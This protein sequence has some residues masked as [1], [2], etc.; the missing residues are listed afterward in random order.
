MRVLD[1][2]ATKVDVSAEGLVA[3]QVGTIVEELAG[4]AYEVEFVDSHG[5]PYA[6]VPLRADQLLVLHYEPAATGG[7]VLLNPQLPD[8]YDQTGK[9]CPTHLR[10][11]ERPW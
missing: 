11:R 9:V 2:V 5:Q 6:L 4:D 3:G 10:D 1:V 7:V 8:T